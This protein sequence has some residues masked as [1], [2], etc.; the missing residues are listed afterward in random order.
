ML[1][2]ISDLWLLLE[3]VIGGDDGLW[4]ALELSL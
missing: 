2:I 4:E 3:L 1:K